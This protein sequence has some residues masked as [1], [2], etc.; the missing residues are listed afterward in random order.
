MVRETKGGTIATESDD[1]QERDSWKAYRKICVAAVLTVQVAAMVLTLRYS[2]TST[3]Y[4]SST[5][6]V[7]SELVKVTV[8]MV[9]LIWQHGPKV[10]SH[11]NAEL[12]AK[13]SDLVAV[14]VPALL[15]LVQN[16]LLFY[17][18]E[19]LD[20]A[21]YQVTYQIKTLTTAVC[22][23]ILLRRTISGQQWA[24][25]LLLTFGVALA[26]FQPTSADTGRA[27]H[28]E[29]SR[30]IVALLVAC[31]TSGFAGVYTEKLLKQTLA[32]LW[33]RNIQLAFWSILAG[34]FAVYTE[35]GAAVQENG[36]FQGYTRVVWAVV[37]LQ[38]ATGICV[39]LVMKFADNIVKNFSVAMSLLLATLVSIPLFGFYPSHLFLVGAFFVLA[40]VVLY[41][42]Q[43]PKRLLRCWGGL[44]KR[45]D[46]KTMDV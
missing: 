42:T 14:S 5:A 19:R 10:F 25:L 46:E 11:L 26:Q 32:S 18:M 38:G 24:A 23:V 43:D 31:F 16:N 7:C 22:T 21:I 27:V 4:L 15:Y 9:V 35:D 33:I 6:V 20:A 17:A 41:S 44:G 2:K 1:A 37:L 13:P 45:V 30:G 28:D 40:S 29:Q 8:C 36:F 3:S 34:L 39:A 12:F